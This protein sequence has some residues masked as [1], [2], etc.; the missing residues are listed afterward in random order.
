MSIFK[1]KIVWITGASSGI[2]E[3]LAKEFNRHEASVILSA[4]N[5]A[6]LNRVQKT[7][8]NAS[9][10]SL[11]LPL[12]ICDVDSFKEKTQEIMNQFGKIDVLINNAGISQ[13]SLAIETTY[14]DE[15]RI[16]DTNLNGPIALTKVV[17]PYLIKNKDAQ[18]VNISS[19]MGKIHTKYRSA[20]A[21]SKHG[22]I[23]YFDCLRLEL[24]SN[25]K[26]T[27]V[28]P[29]FIN[30]NIV[31]NAV[32]KTFNEQNLNKSG[33]SPEVFAIKALDAIHKG[34][35]EIY[36]GGFN[37]RFA[38]FMNQYFP[39]IFNIIIKNKQVT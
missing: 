17:L 3:A 27:N 25:I 36:I 18:I 10:P 16:I 31:K 37:E 24:D 26:I 9:I 12:D 4:R 28:M 23:A 39:A 38:L 34:K 32:S 20:Y 7:F 33:L 29:G 21:A 22:L 1:N 19:V 11:V 14:L 6:E 15:K 2:G 5:I 13:R 8:I 35:H 30:T